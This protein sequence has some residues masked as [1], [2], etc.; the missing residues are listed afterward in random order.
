MIGT[1]T[2]LTVAVG[3]L[4]GSVVALSGRLVGLARKLDDV[5]D[6]SRVNAQLAEMRISAR[7]E[8]DEAVAGDRRPSLQ[9]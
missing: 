9:R 1:T 3:V 6:L 5:R 2:V 8:G 4:L 7:T